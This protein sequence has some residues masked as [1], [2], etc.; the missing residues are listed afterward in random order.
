M[1]IDVLGGFGIDNSLNTKGLEI[2]YGVLLMQTSNWGKS[3]LMASPN[4]TS[5]FFCAGVPCTRLLSSAAMPVV[6]TS[7]DASQLQ[8]Y[9]LLTRI[10]LD[11][12]QTA[13]FL[14]DSNADISGTWTNFEY[15]IC[16]LKV[17]FLD[18]RL[19]KKE[20]AREV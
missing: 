18:N 2:W 16:G 14:E 15:D 6:L 12:D 13:G 1:S 11:G 8:C 3:S 7:A 19:G 4:S 5:S 10:Q 20:S 9:S 17:G